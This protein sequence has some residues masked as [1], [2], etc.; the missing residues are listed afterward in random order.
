MYYSDHTRPLFSISRAQL[1]P[2]APITPPPGCAPDPHK[3]S[4]S[5]GVRYRAH[6]ATGRITNIWSRLIS[7]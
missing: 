4:P 1:Y 2:G 3:Y 6:P 5:T 7:P